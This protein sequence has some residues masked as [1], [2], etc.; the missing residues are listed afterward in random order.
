M[1]ELTVKSKV[2]NCIVQFNEIDNKIVQALKNA[3]DI[4]SKALV[5]HRAGWSFGGKDKRIAIEALQDVTKDLAGSQIE[6]V[7]TQKDLFNAYKSMSQNMTTL[8]QLGAMSLT[9]NRMVYNELKLKLTNASKEQ[10]SDLA[11][12]ELQRTIKQIEDLQDSLI[13]QERQKEKIMMHEQSI[14]ALQ[15]QTSEISKTVIS[16]SKTIDIQG[17][18]NN[19][20]KRPLEKRILMI[21]INVM[22]SILF[23]IITFFFLNNWFAH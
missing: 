4:K 7:Q 13:I 23:S 5:T 8:Y 18:N 1:N 6:L 2:G 11:K 12:A 3:D 16:I 15:N 14:K 17:K 9:A 21:T 10:I 22:V 19:W 20:F